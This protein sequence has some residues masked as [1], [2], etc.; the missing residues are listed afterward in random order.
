MSETGTAAMISVPEFTDLCRREAKFFDLYHFQTL[1]IG[2]GTARVRMP[3][4]ERHVRPGGTISGPAQMALADFSIYAAVLGAIGE[5]PLAVTTSLNINFLN[6][7]APG[8]LLAEARLLKVGKRLAM[9]EVTI[10]SNGVQ[11]PVSHVTA[12]YSIPPS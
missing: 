9:G 6:K 12:T 1:E 10:F 7:P 8:E 11:Q 3:A 4:D 5:V 2:A